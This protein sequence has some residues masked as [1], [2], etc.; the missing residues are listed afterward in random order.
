ELDTASHIIHRVS[1]NSICDDPGIYYI[2]QLVPGEG[3][4]DNP[5]F[6]LEGDTLLRLSDMPRLDYHIRL[7]ATDSSGYSVEQAMTVEYMT[8]P[9]PATGMEDIL[10]RQQTRIYPNPLTGNELF[11]EWPGN[12]I[13]S[14]SI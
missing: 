6:R 4:T 10:G 7:K 1:V 9:P 11:I 12:E 8:T 13:R 3:D 2:Y 5:L 14:V